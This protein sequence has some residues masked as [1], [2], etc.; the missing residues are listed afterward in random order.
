MLISIITVVK[1]NKS[2][3]SHTLQSILNQ[4]YK[5]LE[6]IVIDGCSEDGTDLIVKKYFKKFKLIRKKDKSVYDAMNYAHKIAK[7]DFISFLYSGDIYL[8]KNIIKN[9]MKYAKNYDL[10]STNI[11]YFKDNLKISRIWNADN[12]T[13]KSNYYKYAHT[14][15]FIQKK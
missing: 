2:Q 4:S 3:I 6:L 10:L 15:F 1:N 13:F 8:Q 7:G 5:N 14:G 12:N 11:L 9:T